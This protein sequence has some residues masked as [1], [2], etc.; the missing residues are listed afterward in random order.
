M[1]RGYHSVETFELLLCL[2]VKHPDRITLLRGNHESRYYLL[3]SLD[4]LQLCM[5]FMMKLIENM[6]ILT[7]GNIVLKCLI[8]FHSELLSTVKV[9]VMPDKIFCVHGG[10]SPEIKTIDQVRTIDRKI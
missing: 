9:Y 4:K 7:H 6:E 3:I 5:D 10:L 2:K 8:I 1:D